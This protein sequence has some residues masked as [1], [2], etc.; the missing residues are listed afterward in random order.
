[1]YP[2]VSVIIPLF[3]GALTIESTV[4]SVLNQSVRDLEVIIVNDNSTD[5]SFKVITNVLSNKTVRYSSNP[6]NMGIAAT[7]NH[8]IQLA[9]GNFIAF[10]D[11][12]DLWETEKLAKQLEVF[13]AEPG[14]GL[15]FSNVSYR[16]LGN[17]I[18]GESKVDIGEGKKQTPE[19][20]VIGIESKQRL[21]DYFIP[22][23]S[24]VMVRRECFNKYGYLMNDLPSGDEIEFCSRILK[25]YDIGFVPLP[26]VQKVIHDKNA[27][28]DKFRIHNSRVMLL[29]EILKT[30]PDLEMFRRRKMS[31][32]HYI[33]AKD[34]LLLIGNPKA[35]RK[36]FLKSIKWHHM[37]LPPYLFLALTYF[38]NSTI[39]KIRFFRRK[40]RAL[41]ISWRQSM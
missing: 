23:A 3:N 4:R 35:A 10:L 33:F 1:M 12:D 19:Y 31:E 30:Y 18:I 22:S 28:K 36:E 37:Q 38:N 26:L 15:V 8:G 16:S 2:K 11:Q 27:S 7:R 13:Q 29:N 20:T 21:L 34:L 39:A 9:Q 25:N 41:L 32:F 6:H 24:T 17:N 40:I 14:V 5:N